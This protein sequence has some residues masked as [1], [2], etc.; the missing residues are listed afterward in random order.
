[1]IYT[2]HASATDRVARK[3]G[4]HTVA[5]FFA[6]RPYF[7]DGNVKMFDY[8]LEELGG[9]PEA[10]GQRIGRLATE[11]TVAALGGGEI[12]PTFETICVHSDTPGSPKIAHAISTALLDA[13]VEL[14]APR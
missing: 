10:I 9:T 12:R 3:K 5:E 6:D 4:L 13:G 1:M 7:A 8:C 11:G 14:A 2:I